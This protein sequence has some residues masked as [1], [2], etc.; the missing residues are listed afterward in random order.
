MSIETPTLTQPISPA[1]AGLAC[2]HCGATEFKT[3]WQ[4]FADGIRHAR[5][6]CSRCK[7]FVRYL[8][9]QGAPE[10]RFERAPVDAKTQDLVAPSATWHWIG[11]IRQS[12]RVWR[13][14]AMAATLGQC[15]DAL[16][17]FPGV[18]DYLCVPTRPDA[19]KRGDYGH[20][21]NNV[22]WLEPVARWNVETALPGRHGGRLLG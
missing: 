20:E 21:H 14:V 6:D 19:K 9:Q 16:M 22:D 12:D 10:P 5:A 2:A 13:P 7:R 17:H 8:K 18:G 3:V 1:E 15:W 4:T 11:L